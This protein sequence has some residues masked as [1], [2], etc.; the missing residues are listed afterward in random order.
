VIETPSSVIRSVNEIFEEPTALWPGLKRQTQSTDLQTISRIGSP[1]R[2]ASAEWSHCRIAR[3]SGQADGRMDWRQL[4]PRPNRLLG[5]RL[6]GASQALSERAEVLNSIV[7]CL[8]D[9]KERPF[10]V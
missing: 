10:I 9:P 4:P 8:N 3:S 7:A 2:G 1:A 6:I 5:H